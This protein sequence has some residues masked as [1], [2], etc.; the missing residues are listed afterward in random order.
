MPRVQLITKPN[1][2]LCDA[3]RDV[4]TN[5]CAQFGEDFEE[6]L[7]TDHPQLA[8]IHAEFVPVVMVD[9]REIAVWQILPQALISALTPP[10]V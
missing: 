5:V 9:N 8:A 3:A 1:C 7:I 6:L 2:H 4:V 10:K